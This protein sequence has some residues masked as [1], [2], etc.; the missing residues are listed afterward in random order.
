V[1]RRARGGRTASTLI[2]YFPKDFLMIVDES[3]VTLRRSAAC[4]TA[5]VRAVG[6]RRV[7]VPPAVALDNRPLRREE[8]EQR[9]GSASS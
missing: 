9:V 7:R 3:H 1:A 4:T 5:T 2:D 8:F 6:A